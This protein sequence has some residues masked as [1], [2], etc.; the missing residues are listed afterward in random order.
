M[1]KTDAIQFF[2][3]VTA[4]A[5]ACGVTPGAVSQ[6]P[7]EMP[8]HAEDKVVAAIVRRGLIPPPNLMPTQAPAKG[9]A[10]STA[11]AP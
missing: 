9:E 7:E 5:E 8:R 10:P 3:S 6:W 11:T 4:M 2:T 1:L